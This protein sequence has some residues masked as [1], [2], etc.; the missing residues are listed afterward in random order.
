M[1]AKASYR[2]A[3]YLPRHAFDPHDRARAGDIWRAFQE[4]AVGASTENGWPPARYREH[5]C[6]F[7]MRS[8]NVVHHRA[9]LYGEHF[10]GATWVRR[11]RRDMLSTREVR[12]FSGVHEAGVHEAGVHEA[13]VHEADVPLAS[14]T[15]EW[16]HVDAAMKPVRGTPALIA[17]F[18]PLES[19]SV[20][21]PAWTPS[22]L[23]K[24]ESTFEFDVWN[25]WMDPLGHVNHPHYLDFAEEGLIRLLGQR[26]IDTTELVA[27][28]ESLTFLRGLVAG[29]RAR[30]RTSLVGF[31]AAGLVSEHV[32]ERAVDGVVC[33]RAVLHRSHRRVD[34]RPGSRI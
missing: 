7:V 16:V 25:T 1:S 3:A 29:E 12:L 17:A 19:A 33:A 4:L 11:M 8:M 32:I 5:K 21:L 22:G 30:V 2:A 23:P 18:P 6:A 20:E 28:A 9:A 27:E 26:A 24:A 31:S 15:Q 34:L 14:G 13:G 10:A